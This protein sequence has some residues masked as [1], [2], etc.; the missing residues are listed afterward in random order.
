MTEGKYFL[1]LIVTDDRGATD[2]DNMQIIV[3]GG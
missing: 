1:Q 2:Y 3:G